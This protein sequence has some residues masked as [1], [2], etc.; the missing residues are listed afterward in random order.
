ML[1][2]KK[3]L[4]PITNENW[5]APS[6]ED[7]KASAPGRSVESEILRLWDAKWS[8]RKIAEYLSINQHQVVYTVRKHGKARKPRQPRSVSF[9]NAPIEAW[10]EAMLPELENLRTLLVTKTT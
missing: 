9:A 6:D 7:D 3:Q 10:Q 8:G 1:S 4:T 5:K 2:Y